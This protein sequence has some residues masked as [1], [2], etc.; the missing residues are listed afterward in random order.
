MTVY[1]RR[2]LDAKSRPSLEFGLV[3]Q[4]PAGGAYY[5]ATKEVELP[6]WQSR[7]W[8]KLAAATQPGPTDGNPWGIEKGVFGL[9]SSIPG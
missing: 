9:K 6:A 5:N 3:P 4:A 7:G 8:G 1:Q 2:V